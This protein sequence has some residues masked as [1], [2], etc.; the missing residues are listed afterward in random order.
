MQIVADRPEA[1]IAINLGP[2]S[3][4]ASRP[5]TSI[6]R[7]CPRHPQAPNAGRS[8]GDMTDDASPS[9]SAT[10]A[11][12]PMALRLAATTVSGCGSPSPFELL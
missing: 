2:M 1:L 7:G 5:H 4:V 6:Q 9:M 3:F 8:S 11:G 10:A 12:A